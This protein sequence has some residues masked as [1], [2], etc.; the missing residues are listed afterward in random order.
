MFRVNKREAVS[1]DP[2]AE[3][4]PRDPNFVFVLADDLGYGDV[5]YNGGLPETPYLDAM[6]AGENSLLLT[7]SYSGGPVCS[8]TRG[9]VLTGR[10]HNRYCIW[11]ANLGVGCNDSQCPTSMPLP[12]SEI[13]VAQIL[14]SRGYHTAMFGKW[15]IGDLRRL[16]RGHG[17][18]PV[19]HPGMHGFEEWLV[20][21]RSGITATPNCGCFQNATCITGHYG[22]KPACKN[23]YF[24]SKDEE[25]VK[26]YPEPI[27]GDDS[28]FILEK[29]HKY[30]DKVTKSNQPF[31]AFLSLHTVH[32][33]YIAIEPYKSHYMKKGYDEKTSDYYGAISAMDAVVGKV[34]ELLREYNVSENTLLWFT[35]DNG[36]EMR[37]PGSAG[38][39]RDKKGTLFEGG[40]RVPSIIEWPKMIPTNRQSSFPVVTSDLLPTVCEIVGVEPPRDRPIDGMSI[41]TLIQQRT[42]QRERPIA[43]ASNIRKGNFNSSYTVVLNGDKYKLMLDYNGR[44]VVGSQLYDIVHDPTESENIASAH[45]DVV[46]AMSTELQNWIQSVE[47]SA[48]RV[49]CLGHSGT[50]P[51][52]N[53]AA[54]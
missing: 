7:R 36:P 45:P 35:S 29:F 53:C 37:S 52:C 19:S 21:E 47:R 30:L 15:H 1:G 25:E 22:D 18:W 50:M 39:L 42:S 32:G 49:G 14:R 24:Y 48:Q 40:I 33:R 9:T 17:I 28:H 10:N 11:S 20:T 38:G 27:R 5:G 23:Y 31:F 44:R 54:A 51:S 46:T 6:A 12:T 2:A 16:G 26:G 3:C 4:T 43:F 13:S 8:P 34:R 41:M